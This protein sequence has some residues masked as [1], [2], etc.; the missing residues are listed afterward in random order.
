MARFR[1]SVSGKNADECKE[2]LIDVL[3]SFTREEWL[4]LLI[5]FNSNQ[6]DALETLRGQLHPIPFETVE[7]LEN[8]VADPRLLVFSKRDYES[9]KELLTTVSE[10][11]LEKIHGCSNE[12]K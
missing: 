8:F 12:K 7:D 11:W 9:A 6:N 2:H 4:S 10:N 5:L 1:Y 3:N